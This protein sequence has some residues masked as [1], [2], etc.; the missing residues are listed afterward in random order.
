M[1]IPEYHSIKAVRR[2]YDTGE[3]PVLVKCSDL[4]EYICK[5]MRSSAMPFK[6]IC[7]M[8]GVVSASELGLRIPDMDE[9]WETFI[10][11]YKDMTN[12]TNAI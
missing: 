9:S 12:E 7:E 11:Y 1:K 5:Y 2:Q 6:L 8:I 3:E 4:N 10:N